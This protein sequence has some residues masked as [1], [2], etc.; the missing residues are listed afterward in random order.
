MSEW[1]KIKTALKNGDVVFLLGP[2]REENSWWATSGRWEKH[3]WWPRYGWWTE[4]GDSVR[5]SPTH[6]MPVPAPPKPKQTIK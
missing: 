3:P 2:N 5:C 6:W 1:Q 4:R